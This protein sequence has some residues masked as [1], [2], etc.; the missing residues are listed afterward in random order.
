MERDE[1]GNL[2]MT[3]RGESEQA[4]LIGG[5]IDSVPNGGWLDGCLNTL[6]GVEI[7][8]RITAEGKPPVTV[9][10]V[11][12]A[13]E[14]GARFGKSLFGSSACSGNLDMEEARGL[15]DKRRHHAAGRV[16]RAGDRFRE[17]EG[18]RPSPNERGGVSGTAHRAGAGAARS[19]SAAR[20][21]ARDVRCRAARD[22][23]SR[24][25]G[26]LRQHADEPAPRCLS[27][28]GEE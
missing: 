24:P 26:A 15:K 21:G 17:S 22:H 2:W 28:R 7:L 3:L 9:R 19:R 12:W 10:L 11:D 6:A 20:R 8:R 5:H 16:A 4:L 27:R 23:F 18:E 13:D 1:A 14:E 25:G